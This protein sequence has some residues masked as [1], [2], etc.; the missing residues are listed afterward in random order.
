MASLRTWY[1]TLTY[2]AEAK[3]LR[4]IQIYPALIPA[5]VDFAPFTSS[6]P[7]VVSRMGALLAKAAEISAQ[8][9]MIDEPTWSE[10]AKTSRS[11]G[12]PHHEGECA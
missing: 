8:A 2:P 1:V 5:M 6:S 4:N 9:A 3:Q 10:S 11:A 12:G 7:V